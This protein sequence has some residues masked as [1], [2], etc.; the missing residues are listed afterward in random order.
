MALWKDEPRSNEQFM[1]IVKFDSR[2]GR[3][4]RIDRDESGNNVP[5][6][7]TRHFKAVFDM[8]HID[9][10]YVKFAA[11]V[12]PDAVW[13]PWSDPMVFP[14]QPSPDHRRGFR[15]KVKLHK[16]CGGDLRELSG[17]AKAL[18]SG[19][20]VLHN[21][22]LEERQNHPG[23]VP[24]VVLGEP[25]VMVTQNRQGTSTNYAPTFDIVGWAN[26]PAEFKAWVPQAPQAPVARPAAPPVTGSTRVPPPPVHAPPVAAMADDNDFG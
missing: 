20:N 5:T 13:A 18:V 25:T 12:A 15:I 10:G 21:K 19:L 14:E 11:G 9:V 23:K 4:S 2:S 3:M 1:D 22:W 16:D 26:T 7:I 17:N 8:E 24:V 6:E